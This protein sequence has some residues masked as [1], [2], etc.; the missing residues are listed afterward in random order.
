MRFKTNYEKGFGE[1]KYMPV[2]EHVA[3]IKN[4]VWDNKEEEF[5]G[6]RVELKHFSFV[7]ENDKGEVQFDKFWN[8]FD[9]ETLTTTYQLFKINGYSKS[10]GIP[11]GTEFNS[12]Q[13][14]ID[15]V[16]GRKLVAVVEERETNNGNKITTVRY[17]K[18]LD[19]EDNLA[20]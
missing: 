11:E 4:I 16:L 15:Y 18:P 3:T 7:L 12:I 17:V 9:E 1:T 8:N 20:F 19:V 2:G 10:V 6:M 14:W 5:N 13:E